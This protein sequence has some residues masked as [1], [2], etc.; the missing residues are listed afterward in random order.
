MLQLDWQRWEAELRL[1]VGI[2]VGALTS[3]LCLPVQAQ[4]NQSRYEYCQQ[5]AADFSGYRGPVPNRYLPGGALDGAAKGAASGAVGSLIF[6]GNKKERKK[7]AKR[8]A[9]IGGIVGALKRGAAKKE[10][11]KKARIYRLELDACMGAAREER[12]K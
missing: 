2:M 12:R 7:A 8:G 3:V 9:I 6:G 5:R 11:R 1:K 10:Q 4:Y